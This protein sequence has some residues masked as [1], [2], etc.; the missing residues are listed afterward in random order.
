MKHRYEITEKGQLLISTAELTQRLGIDRM[1]LCNYCKAGMPRERQ[2]W[3]DFWAIREWFLTHSKNG[4]KQYTEADKLTADVK[5]KKAK[6]ELT[7]IEI[8]VKNG[9]LVE[10]S[11]VKST[12]EQEF[13]KLKTYLLGLGDRVLSEVVLQY[14]EL[15]IQ[16]RRIINDGIRVGLEELANGNR[17]IKPA[18]TSRPRKKTGRP[19]K[20]NK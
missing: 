8:A 4:D 17:N 6:E 12:L 3:Y 11:M 1:T 13:S 15:A 5:L 9:E 19:R 20:V 14:P 16:V 10:M 18:T 7:Q 2:G